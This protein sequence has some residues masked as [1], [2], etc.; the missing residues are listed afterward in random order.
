MLALHKTCCRRQSVCHSSWTGMRRSRDKARPPTSLP[1]IS[2]AKVPCSCGRV[3]YRLQTLLLCPHDL[4]ISLSLSAHLHRRRRGD[5]KCVLW[6]SCLF[7]HRVVL[8]FVASREERCSVTET[9]QHLARE[10]VCL[11]LKMKPAVGFTRVGSHF[12]T[13][14][15]V[16]SDDS[17]C[18]LTLL[19]LCLRECA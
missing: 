5:L 11:S 14:S 17:A 16:I 8:Q 2:L 9:M 13:Q 4:E 1:S 3:H 18:L 12:S 19:I 6:I 7:H 15:A 10:A